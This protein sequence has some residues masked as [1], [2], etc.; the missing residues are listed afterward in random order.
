[1]PFALVE[2]QR[3]TLRLAALD[4]RAAKLGLQIGLGLGEARARV[5]ELAALPFAPTK[6]A[7][8]MAKLARLC[9]NYTPSVAVD[10]PHAALHGLVLDITGCAHLHGG[11]PALVSALVAR[12]GKLGITACAALGDTADAARALA[13]FG[14]KDVPA[15][16]LAALDVDPETLMALR[17]AGFRRIGDIAELP[18]APLAARFGSEL[19]RRLGHLLGEQDPH[20]V[21]RREAEPIVLVQRFAEPIARTDDVLDTIAMLLV[22]AA[23]ELAKC[24]AGGRAF[25]VRL[26]RSDGHVARLAVATS[27]PTRDPALVMRLLRERI[28]SLADPLDPGFGYDAI[29]L[30]VP[31]WEPLAERLEPLPL[32]GGV[33]GGQVQAQQLRLRPIEERKKG[34]P[35]T[36]P[37]SGRGE[38][39]E[40]IGPLLDR[41]A[42]RYGPGSVL[43]FTGADSHIPERA[44]TLRPV[45]A[46]PSLN[47]PPR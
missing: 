35:P 25:A 19:V 18:R 1:M 41:L 12:F 2:H 8:L 30:A 3:G 13:R 24:A 7:A 43:R 20:I 36:P 40:D 33:W 14:A 16:P 39:G 38:D 28:D 37:A 15:L 32:A 11:E 4:P 17:R 23:A 34:P 46:S 21:P 22:R 5:P 44:G 29:D 42:V 9:G 27:A 31:R 10:P 45:Q 6:D 47:E 26:H